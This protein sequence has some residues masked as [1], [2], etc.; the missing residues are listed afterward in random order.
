MLFISIHLVHIF[1]CLRYIVCL[2]RKITLIHNS[3]ENCY[4]SFKW[5]LKKDFWYDLERCSFL[6]C[7]C[8]EYIADYTCRFVTCKICCLAPSSCTTHQA[9]EKR[10]RPYRIPRNG[11]TEINLRWDVSGYLWNTHCNSNVI[12]AYTTI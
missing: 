5:C 4:W 8:G 6:W 2:I 9:A 11:V 12:V 1:H 10:R 7:R 3:F